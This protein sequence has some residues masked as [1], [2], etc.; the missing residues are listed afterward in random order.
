MNVV[1]LDLLLPLTDTFVAVT[2]VVVVTLAASHHSEA[3]LMIVRCFLRLLLV[4]S[5]DCYTG[6][7]FAPAV[8]SF[9]LLFA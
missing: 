8:F 6:Y 7:Y 9:L 3:V 4:T 1:S 2:L 5:C